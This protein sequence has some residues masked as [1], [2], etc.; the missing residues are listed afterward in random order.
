MKLV[1]NY[2]IKIY[3]LKNYHSSLQQHGSQC[4]M[5]VTIVSY[6]ITHHISFDFSW[7]SSEVRVHVWNC[8]YYCPSIYIPTNIPYYVVKLNLREN[9]N[10]HSLFIVPSFLVKLVDKLSI[11]LITYYHSVLLKLRLKTKIIL[12]K[13]Y[14]YSLKSVCI[15]HQCIII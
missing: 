14:K 12:I 7:K 15:N 9:S 8:P 4:W 10:A 2:G 11:Q 3:F 6:N 5:L 13:V 1:T